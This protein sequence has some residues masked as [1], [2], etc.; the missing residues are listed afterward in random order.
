M[1]GDQLKLSASVRLIEG[2]GLESVVQQ[3]ASPTLE[4][5]HQLPCAAGE[6]WQQLVDESSAVLQ[7]T[8]QPCIDLVA[9]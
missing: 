8:I 3:D 1:F 9:V 4:I 2:E 7:A 6:E 5:A